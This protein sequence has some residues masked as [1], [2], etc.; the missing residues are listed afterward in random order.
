MPLHIEVPQY[1]PED[2]R[3]SP[4]TEN[5]SERGCEVLDFTLSSRAKVNEV[6]SLA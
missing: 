2:E 5:P 3:E 1:Q 6:L 4:K